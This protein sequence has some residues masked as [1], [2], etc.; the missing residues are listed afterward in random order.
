[1]SQ[2]RR[3]LILIAALAAAIP[4]SGVLAFFLAGAVVFPIVEPH[5]APRILLSLG[6]LALVYGAECVINLGIVETCGFASGN[7]STHDLS[8]HAFTLWLAIGG[9]STATLLW[10]LA[11]HL[12]RGAG[13]GG[14]A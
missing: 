14:G 5:Y 6:F 4:L 12:Q 3:S 11:R 7:C 8:S 10:Y 1:M 2:H 9:A 13:D